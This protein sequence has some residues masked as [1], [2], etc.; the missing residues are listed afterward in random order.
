MIHL[1]SPGSGLSK[2]L[3]EARGGFLWWYLDLVDEAGNGLVAIWSY[4]LPFLPGYASAARRGQAPMASR[5]PSLTVSVY[6]QGELDVYLLQE[7]GPDEVVWEATGTGDRWEYGESRLES[8]VVGGERQVELDLRLEIPGMDEPLRVVA[9]SQGPGV[10]EEGQGHEPAVRAEAPLPDHDWTPILCAAPG[11]VILEGPEGQE[12]IS[13]R[14]YHDRNGGRRPLHD[15]GIDSWVWGRVALPGEE[16]IYYVLDGVDGEQECLFLRIGEDGRREPVEGCVLKRC[17]TRKN[18]G[19]LRWWPTMTVERGGEEWLRIEHRDVV[20]SGPFYLRSVLR[21]WDGRGEYRGIAEVC[22][23]DRVDLAVHRPLVKMRVHRRRGENSMW[24]P[25]FS[26][27]KKGRVS[28]LLKSV[29]G[30]GS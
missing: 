12:L 15:L 30:G 20:D 5:R 14:V 19:G 24:L 13:G 4:G 8:V 11:R 27:P 22:E 3:L 18:L 7:Y 16:F 2:G 26:G 10:Y 21:A 9:K 17:R 29:M 25:L 1:S 28:R 6:R 23:P